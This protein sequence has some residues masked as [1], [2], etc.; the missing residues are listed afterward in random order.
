MGRKKQ[1]ALKGKSMNSFK[2]IQKCSQI[3]WESGR[4]AMSLISASSY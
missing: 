2:F 1:T 3:T 4:N